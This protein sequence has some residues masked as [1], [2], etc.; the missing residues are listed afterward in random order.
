MPRGRGNFAEAQ[1][2]FALESTKS[3]RFSPLVA[4]NW[5]DLEELFGA[6]GACGGCWCMTWRLRHAEFQKN[7][8]ASNKRAFQ[9]IVASGEATGVLAY[10]AGKTVGWCAIAPRDIYVRLESSRILRPVDVQ[11]VWAVS[12]FYVARGHR[13]S[14]LSV[15]LLEAAVEYARRRGAKIVEGY[16]HDLR[17]HLPGAFVWTGIFSTFRKVGFEEVARRSPTRPIVRKELRSLDGP[18]RRR[19]NG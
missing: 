12:C 3:L 17:E 4:A 6:R 8:G 15:A 16:P 10:S 18:R 14:G 1:M 7:K 5:S 11:P 13:R 19:S 9:A 2:N